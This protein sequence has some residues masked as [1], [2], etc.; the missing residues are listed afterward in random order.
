MEDEV[1]NVYFQA[2]LLTAE[3]NK[4]LELAALLHYLQEI[5]PDH[6]KT[7]LDLPELG[8]RKGYYLVMVDKAFGQ[9]AQVGAC[10]HSVEEARLDEAERHRAA[11]EAG[12]FGRTA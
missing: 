12:Q 3:D 7:L 6:F 2:V 1:A 5:A 4:F 10:A 11:F 9:F 8:R